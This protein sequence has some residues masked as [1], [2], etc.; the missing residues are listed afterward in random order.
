MRKLRSLLQ[1]GVRTLVFGAAVLLPSCTSDGNF[2]ILGYT[3]EPNYDKCIRTVAV[4]VFKNTTFRQGFEFE[5]TK[6][7]IHEIESKTPY[8]VVNG[9]GHADTELSGT[10]TM[11]PKNII[12]RT[13]LNEIRQ[14]ELVLSVAVQWRDL[15]TGDY[16]TRPRTGPGA[17][18]PADAPLGTPSAPPPPVMLTATVDFLPELGESIATA[19][20]K[21]CKRL[22]VQIVSM[23]E[24]PW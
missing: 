24:K 9:F 11:V 8:K 21:A 17:A 14:G 13:P 15:R 12:L 4:P 5:L 7:V 2:T 20:Q 10:I 6:A 22:A 3:T 1:R 18:P 23:M 19:E 16:L